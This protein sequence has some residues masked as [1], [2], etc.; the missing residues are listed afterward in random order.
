M[1]AY[2]NTLSESA[3]YV[4]GTHTFPISADKEVWSSHGFTMTVISKLA[5][6]TATCMEHV[7]PWTPSCTMASAGLLF[8]A[9]P[10]S[11]RIYTVVYMVRT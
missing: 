2:H 11:F 3:K 4:R 8:Q 6:L 1:Y 5:P 10:E 9:V 7:H